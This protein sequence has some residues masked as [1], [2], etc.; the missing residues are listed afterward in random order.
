MSYFN[1]CVLSTVV[2]QERQV[3]FHTITIELNFNIISIFILFL[4]FRAYFCPVALYIK[5]FQKT[6]LQIRRLAL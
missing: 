6:T 2:T 1:L 3:A 5:L 4:L